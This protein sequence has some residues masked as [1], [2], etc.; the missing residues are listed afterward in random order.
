LKKLAT[1]VLAVPLLVGGACSHEAPLA[2]RVNPPGLARPT[3]YTHVVQVEGGRTLYVSGQVA[4]DQ[5]G[6][7]VGKGDFRAQTRQVFENLK[8]ALASCGATLD[9]V[10]KITIF[11]TDASE[12]QGFREIR[13]AYFTKAPP[14][15]SFFQ[16]VRLAQP[17]FM[18]EVEAIAVTSSGK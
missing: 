5:T 10:V 13:D 18:V 16:V 4:R 6:N 9:D 2:K 17:D 12:I 3:G 7:V 8:T 1:M 15:S 14:A 11:V